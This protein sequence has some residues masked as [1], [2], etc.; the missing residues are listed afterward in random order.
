[1]RN[2]GLLRVVSLFVAAHLASLP[3]APVWGQG[4]EY[5][6]GAGDVLEIKVWQREELGGDVTVDADGNITLPLIGT[7]RGAGLTTARLAEELTRRFSF[8]DREVS[9]VTVGAIAP[10]I[11]N[12]PNNSRLNW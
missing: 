12:I 1:M 9:Q 8:V 10:K 5:L 2:R 6:I 4:A 11:V 3:V 7:I